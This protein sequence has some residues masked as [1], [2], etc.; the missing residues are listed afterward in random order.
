MKKATLVVSDQHFGDAGQFYR[1]LTECMNRAITEINAF[2]P[3]EIQIVANGDVVAG[4]GIFR[5]QEMQ[6]IVQ[7]GPE[8]VYWAGWEIKQWNKKFDKEAEWHIILGNHD[9]SKRENLARQ[10]V[11][12]LRLLGINSK[13]ED[14]EYIGYFGDK[15]AA[16]HVSHGFG[17]SSYYANSYAEIRS[18]WKKFIE[19]AQVNGVNITRFIR[20]HVHKLNIGQEIGLDCQI[21]TSGGWHKQERLSLEFSVRTTGVLLYLYNTDAQPSLTIK[22]IEA[23]RDLLL[24]E[25][26]NIALHYR[27]MEAAGRALSDV[28]GWGRV[29]GIW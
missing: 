6:N 12:F 8:Q 29:E 27:N 28:A 22:A 16:F 25:N 26:K 13:Y 19:I 15:E 23:N 14:R 3:D 5:L 17:Y 10:L 1:P 24:A 7:L 2:E 4:R 11:L 9:N 18:C 21:D 20:A